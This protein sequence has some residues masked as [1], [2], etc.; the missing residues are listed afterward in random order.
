M[1]LDRVVVLHFHADGED[2]NPLH[3]GTLGAASLSFHSFLDGTI[4]GFAFQVSSA[5]GAIVTVAVLTHD[6]SD[7]INTVSLVLKN[8]GTLRHAFWWLLVDAF[9]PV[10]GISF[11]LLFSLPKNALGGVL[12]IFCGCFIYI[13][14]S[15]LLPESHHAHPKMLTTVMTLL[16]I[17]LLYAVIQVAK[18]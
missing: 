5:V 6:F 2:E 13:G 3:R 17:S 12:A 4:I 18:M 15:E 16:G 14:A 1:L 7:G 10:L 8:Q 11:T 9:A